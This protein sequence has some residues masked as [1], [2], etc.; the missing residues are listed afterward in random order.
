MRFAGSVSD[1]QDVRALSLRCLTIRSLLFLAKI[2]SQDSNPVGMKCCG[3]K[4]EL[5]P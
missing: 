3:K 4:A 5:D 1:V 2:L